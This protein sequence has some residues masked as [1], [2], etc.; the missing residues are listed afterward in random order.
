[1]VCN[2]A[3]GF[4]RQK[5]KVENLIITLHFS[6]DLFEIVFCFWEVSD[7]RVQKGTKVVLVFAD[8]SPDLPGQNLVEEFLIYGV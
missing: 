4:P 8:K 7:V 5:N 6:A 1:M 2:Q 3:C